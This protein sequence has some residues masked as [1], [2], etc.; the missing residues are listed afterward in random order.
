MTEIHF[1]N[2]LRKQ[3]TDQSD[4]SILQQR[5]QLL[6]ENRQGR[7]ASYYV[8]KIQRQKTLYSTGCGYS[9]DRSGCG[10]IYEDVNGS[11]AEYQSAVCYRHDA[12]S[13]GQSGN[14]GDG[15]DKAGGGFH[16]YG[17]QHRRNQFCFQREL[18]YGDPGIC[19]VGG[20]E[21]RLFGDQRE[22]GSDQELLG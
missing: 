11:A 18:F 19:T 5:Y 16:G 4:G 20:Y 13:R 17:Q 22:S 14:R 9:G 12:V 15:G 21:R 2:I 8:G 3:P 10:F 1:L 7:G 6:H